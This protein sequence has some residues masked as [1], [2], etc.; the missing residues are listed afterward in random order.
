[1]KNVKEITVKIEK[2]EWM[3]FLKEAFNKNKKDIKVDGFRKGSVTWDLY[4]K[5]FGVQSLFGEAT[6]LVLDKKYE[7]AL[8]EAD[9]VPVVQPT[10]DILN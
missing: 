8:K 2:E 7:S 1:M 3:S 10:V 4:T 5:K 9:V 6:D